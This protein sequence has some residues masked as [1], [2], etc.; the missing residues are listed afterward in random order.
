MA[1]LGADAR[2]APRTLD[3]MRAPMRDGVERSADYPGSSRNP[4]THAAPGDDDV[5]VV[6]H[7][8]ERHSQAYP[9]RLLAPV[10]VNR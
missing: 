1:G 10:P 2:T 6:T 3:D 9:S 8:S 4:T 5:W 7:N